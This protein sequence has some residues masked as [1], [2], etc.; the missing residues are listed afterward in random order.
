M[1]EEKKIETDTMIRAKEK[2][3]AQQK[4]ANSADQGVSNEINARLVSGSVSPNM[5]VYP[6]VRNGIVILHGRVPD[7]KTAERVI[8]SVRSTPGVQ[9]IISNLVVVSQQTQAI[10]GFTPALNQQQQQIP[11][12]QVQQQ[13]P[14]Q[15]PLLQ[16]RIPQQQQQFQQRMPQQVP[17]QYIP[18]QSGLRNQP[19]Y[20][21]GGG[22][23]G[24]AKKKSANVA[25]NYPKIPSVQKRPVNTSPITNRPKTMSLDAMQQYS[26]NDDTYVKYQQPL[27]RRQPVYA[28][29]AP[30]VSP[31]VSNPYIVNVPT[32][33]VYQD[34]DS[35]YTPPGGNNGFIGEASD[36]GNYQ[37]NDST[38]D[39]IH[40]Y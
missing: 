20:Y 19:N 16:Q 6:E 9:R 31:V 18:P 27:I 1:R 25:K 7:P 29:P 36:S 17:Q 37:D 35:Y 32:P 8:G 30:T 39:L 13:F 21:T 26:D 14:Q 24:G 12:V 28:Q 33:T 38:Y 10:S 15:A 3:E 4:Q 34:N 11:Q 22:N 2:L 40:Y 23:S 5:A